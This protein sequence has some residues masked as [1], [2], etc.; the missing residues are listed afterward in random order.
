MSLTPRK[1]RYLWLWAFLLVAVVVRIWMASGWSFE[2]ISVEAP[3]P[4]WSLWKSIPP[5][6]LTIINGSEPETLDPALITSLADSR[7]V[8]CLFEGL[9]R[10]NGETARA[11]PGIAESWDISEDG[12]LYTFHLRKSAIWS[13]GRP[14]TSAD[15]VY[16]WQRALDPM[17]A[18]DYAGQLYYIENAEAFNT[19]G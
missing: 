4:R 8:R 9:T 19:G 12:K 13:D 2:G 5:A 7:I 10:L 14:I 1:A 6:D 15:V 11:E 17:T 16:S 3:R 18:A